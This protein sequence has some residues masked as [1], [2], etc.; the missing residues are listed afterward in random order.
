MA[1]PAQAEYELLP[2]AGVIFPL[3]EGVGSTAYG[4]ESR[5]LQWMLGA[6]TLTRGEGYLGS[7]PRVVNA[8]LIYGGEVAS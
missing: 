7:C 2:R 4:F 1:M 5:Y 6:G 3:A 8:C